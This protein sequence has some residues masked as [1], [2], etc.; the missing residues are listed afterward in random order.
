MSNPSLI[1]IL[2]TSILINNVVLSLFLG[3]CPFLG[4]SKKVETALGMGA[5]VIFIMTLSSILCGLV[6]TFLLHPFKLD[7]LDTIIFVLIIAALARFAELYLKKTLPGIFSAPGVCHPLLAA[8]CVVLGTVLLNVQ[9]KYNFLQGVINGF[10][11][12]LGFAVSIVILAGLREKMEYNRI[13]K[14]VRG[15]PL[16]LFTAALMAVAFC[17]FAGLG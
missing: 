11:A 12:S 6:H 7:Y 15:L 4:A 14:A 1:S 17:G 8:G 16:T 10:G 3:I 13:P 9:A 2:I 5:A